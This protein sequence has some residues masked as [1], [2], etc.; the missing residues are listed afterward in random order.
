[1]ATNTLMPYRGSYLMPTLQHARVAD[2]MHPGVHTCDPDAT[3][4]E[5]ARVMATHHIHCVAVMGVGHDAAGERLAW[6]L[7]SDTDL[8]R[9]SLAG[10]DPT[11]AA[12]TTAPLE[13]LTPDTPL[14]EAAEL[15]LSRG[16]THLLVIDP[17]RERPT[18]VLST[19]D[20]AGT[21]AWAEG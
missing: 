7:I 13:T 4:T 10:G 12:L 16:V 17:V 3:L 18:G 14:R 1:M 2:A 15:M 5:V 9:A 11:A 8:V 20:I 21:V 6:R 19:F